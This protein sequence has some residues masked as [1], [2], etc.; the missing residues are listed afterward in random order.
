ML[1][2]IDYHNRDQEH[3][4]SASTA[5]GSSRKHEHVLAAH[6]FG[7]LRDGSR[8]S[9]ADQSSIT[10]YESDTWLRKYKTDTCAT[11]GDV[12]QFYRRNRT[13]ERVCHNAEIEHLDILYLKDSETTSRRIS[14]V[15]FPDG[16]NRLSNMTRKIHIFGSII[17]IQ[18]F[19]A[20]RVQ[21][22]RT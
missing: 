14:M 5:V 1:P 3:G 15:P 9:T 18:T 10:R 2:T 4:I 7:F 22:T 8:P 6:Y 21:K 11:G 17:L 12:E 20:E 19:P 16:G 13:L